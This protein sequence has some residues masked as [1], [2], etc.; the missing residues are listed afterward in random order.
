MERGQC[1]TLDFTG[2]GDHAFIR[3]P[4]QKMEFSVTHASLLRLY[5]VVDFYCCLP[6]RPIETSDDMIS[7]RVVVLLVPRPLSRRS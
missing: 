6:S 2:L 7:N 4:N 1:D 5:I 3:S